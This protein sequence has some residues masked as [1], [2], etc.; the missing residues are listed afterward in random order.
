MEE[1]KDISGYEKKHQASTEGRI[2]KLSLDLETYSSADLSKSGVYRY[3]EA[4]D[5]EILLFGY[6]FDESEP[7][8]VDLASGEKL[9]QEVLSALTDPSV[10]KWAFN[11]QFE[12]VCLSRYLGFPT[13]EYLD[14][15]QWRCSM[16]WSAYMGLPLSLKGVGTILGLEKQKLEEGKDLIRYFCVPCLPTKANGGRT[17]NLPIHNKEKWEQFKSYNIRDV[18]VELQIQNKLSK[19]P[20]PD[21]IW[22]E[23]R[24][25]QQINDRGVRVDMPFVE[26]AIEI[27]NKIKDSLASSI[28]KLTNLDNPNSVMQ[29]KEWLSDNGL[30]TASLGK[31]DVKALLKDADGDI[32]QVL[33]IRQ[34]LA[35]SSVR[36]YAAIKESVCS[37]G[38]L[39]GC[40]QFYGA[41]RTGRFAGRLVQLQNLP[42]NHLPDLAEAR[43]L[44]RSG[45]MDALSL[46]YDDIPDVL[47]QLIRTAFIPSE[48]KRFFVAD[49]SAIEA[50]V[51]AWFAKEEWRTRVFAEGGDIY[52]RSASQMFKVPVEKH[53][54]NSHLRQKGKIAEL[55]CIA[56]DS[57]VLTDHG[58][59]PIQDVSLKD[60]LW[61]GEE[62]VTHEGVICRGRKEVIEYEGLTATA[63]HLVWTQGKQE[64]IHFG[65]AAACGAHLIK[66]ADGGKT[67]WLGNNNLSG[68][69]MEC[70]Y[71]PL[72]CHDQMQRMRICPMAKSEQSSTRNFQGLSELFPANKSPQMAYEKAVSCEKSLRE[73]KRQKLQK[74]WWKRNQVCISKSV[75][76]RTVHDK[77]W[78]SKQSNGDR[79]NR[80]EWRLCAGE[81]AF[82]FTG[83]KPCKQE[84]NCIV[85]VY[86]RI[87]AL[88]TRCRDPKAFARFKQKTDNNGSR[89]GGIRKTKELETHRGTAR[90]YDI[91]NA[92]KHHR[93]TV[94]GCL[95]HNCGYGGSVGA[96]KAM[97]A[98][99]FGLTEDELQP[100]VDAWRKASPNIVKFWWD[101]D[102]AVKKA[103]D[104]KTVQEVRG[105]RF[106][107]KSGILFIT[108]PSGREL[109]YV[110]PRLAMNEYGSQIITYE[111]TGGTK[112]WERIE[113]YG[114]KFVENI[115]QAIS[116]DILM[117]SMKTLRDRKIVAHVHDELIIEA[118]PDTSLDEICEKMAIVPDWAE[119]LI[120]NAD[121][122]VCDYYQKS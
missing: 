107:F 94:S 32:E 81:S 3:A 93:F 110:K 60:R 103:I 92:G 61:D 27:D 38:R 25:D 87:L 4:P 72:L 63:E 6:S 106:S 113:S 13:G 96:L 44:A 99:D 52:C 41:N 56:E 74:L 69:A 122:Y 86:A 58:L 1:W 28:K 42:Q 47:S 95:V 116:R 17:R 23:Y 20:V 108:L 120:L 40:F 67:I 43:S 30:E 85:K 121:G 83:K 59:I 71:E 10:I 89:S 33:S 48:G 104:N 21:S 98:L 97:G 53:G 19:F 50:R 51:I 119:D 8:V 115:V 46:L 90:V 57:L 79:Q 24:I 31:K 102:S 55:A 100:L 5:F 9:P 73:S 66:T 114:P 76:S 82:C 29:M 84:N 118:D 70:K 91:R 112:K 109:A 75:G 35:K 49:F 37:D 65:I 111:G 34:Q 39:R 22:D 26:N 101:V 78:T 15:A 80:Y 105:V 11:A 36:K 16:V 88:L 64:P 2:R 68:K 77:S 54:L 7:R 62:W 14:P 18:E 12:R 45:K 117:N